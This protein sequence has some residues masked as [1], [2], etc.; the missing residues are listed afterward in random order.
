MP[1]D[2]FV[3]LDGVRLHH[4]DWGGDGE[5]VL[6]LAGLGCTAHVFAELAPHLSDRFR[7][8]ALTRPGHGASERVRTG[9]ALSDGA[10]DARRL[11]DAL[12]IARAHVVGHSMGGGEASAL[13]ARHPRRV[14]SVVYLD[15]AYDWADNPTSKWQEET[16]GPDHFASYEDYVDHVHALLPD[17]RGPAFDAMLRSS[18]DTRPD[19]SVVD[20]HSGPDFAPFVEA[21]TRFRHPYTDIAAPALAIYAIGDQREG[22]EAAWR[23]ACRDRFTQDTADGRVVDLCGSDYLFIDRRDDVVSAMREHLAQRST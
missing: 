1:S 4:L 22:P 7:V 11:L 23:A 17:V 20:R 3:V 12:G 21:L 14:A 6:L 10:E 16:P 19:G 15:G 18:V 2:Q 8:V 9:Y 13:A 5:P